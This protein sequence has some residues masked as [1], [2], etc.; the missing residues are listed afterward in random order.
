M[1]F[2]RRLTVCQ[3]ALEWDPLS[4]SKRDPFDR[5]V[6][7]VALASS[8]LVGVAETARARV[9]RTRGGSRLSVALYPPCRHL[10]SPT[11]CTRRER[12]HVQLQ[13]LSCRRPSAPQG[14]DARNK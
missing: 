11:N 8:E 5:R 12:R 4:A 14:H 13:R 7:L 1:I 2:P 3:S 9:R 10:Q 6:L